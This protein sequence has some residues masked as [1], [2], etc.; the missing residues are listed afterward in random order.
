MRTPLKIAGCRQDIGDILRR[1]M[2]KMQIQQ[3][4]DMIVTVATEI[5]LVIRK[6]GFLAM[7]TRGPVCSCRKVQFVSFVLYRYSQG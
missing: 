5:T 1:E 4:L 6:P 7:R 3:M 2:T